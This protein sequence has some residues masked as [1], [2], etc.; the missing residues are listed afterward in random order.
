MPVAVVEAKAERIVALG[1]CSVG[2]EGLDVA[3]LAELLRR[4]A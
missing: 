1:P 4:L 3:T 2:I